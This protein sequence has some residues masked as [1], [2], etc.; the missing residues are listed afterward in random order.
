[1]SP[2]RTEAQRPPCPRCAAPLGS[3]PVLDAVLL[4]CTSCDGVFVPRVLVARLDPLDLGGE[5]LTSFP[6]G[7]PQTEASVRY[8]RCPFDGEFMHRRLVSPRAK[9]IVDECRAHG[10]WF[11][12]HELRAMIERLEAD[13]ATGQAFADG[14]RLGPATSLPTVADVWRPAGRDRGLLSALLAVLTRRH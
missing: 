2:Y 14:V 11:D 8:L 13:Q 1:M 6:A 10:V 5:I 9:V 7:E 3:Q 12:Q 4:R